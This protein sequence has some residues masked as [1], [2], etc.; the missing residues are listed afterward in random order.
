MPRPPE[1]VS[2][3]F[4]ADQARELASAYHINKENASRAQLPK[5]LAQIKKRAENGYNVVTVGVSAD[6]PTP[7]LIEE[8]EK[9]GF[10]AV[11]TGGGYSTLE[12]S[13]K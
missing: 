4:N 10:K 5:V 6:L 7:P 8:L 1:Q 9:R 11:I 3:G 2:E 12:V 13:W